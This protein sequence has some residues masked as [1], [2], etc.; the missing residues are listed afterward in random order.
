MRSRGINIIFYEDGDAVE[1]AAGA[2]FLAFF[3]EGVGDGEGVGIGF[4]HA[5]DGGAA[6][7][8]RVN[9]GEVEFGDRAGGVFAGFHA[10]L[11]VGDS[12]FV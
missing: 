12:D 9:A 3:V 8:Y 11:Q 2:F 1:R 10:V 6:F 7:V 5:V 4:D